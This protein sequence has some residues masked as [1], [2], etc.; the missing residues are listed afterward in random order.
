MRSTLAVLV[1]TAFFII[2]GQARAQTLKVEQLLEAWHVS[3]TSQTRV[4][5]ATFDDLKIHLNKDSLEQRVRQIKSFL[6]HHPDKRLQARLSMYEAWGKRISPEK[7]WSVIQQSQI[8][9]DEQL[10]SELFT[11]YSIRLRTEDNGLYYLLKAIEI[12]EKIGINQFPS[13]YYTYFTVSRWMYETMDY[14]H[15]VNYGRKGI[16][17]FRLHHNKHFERYILALDILGAAYKELGMSDS[18]LFY[19]QK[20]KEEL[21]YQ[22]ANRAKSKHTSQVISIWR[23][24]AKGGIAQALLLQKKYDSAYL[25]LQQNMQSS[26]GH[27]EWGDAA[28]VSNTMAQINMIKKNYSGALTQYKQARAWSIDSKGPVNRITAAKG[29][30]SAFAALNKYDS[31][32]HY[33]KEYLQWHDSLER[34]VNL[35]QLTNAQ[36]QVQYENMQIA[37]AAS[38]SEIGR[39]KLLRN[40][41][42]ISV[43]SLTV[44]ALMFYNRSLLKQKLKHEKLEREK[45]QAEAEVTLAQQELED[46]AKHISEKNNLIET[47]QK[48]ASER[49]QLD[50]DAALYNFAILTEDDWL[51]FKSM[52]TQAYPHF[53]PNLKKE[54]PDLNPAELRF[55]SLYKLNVSRK[56]MAATLGITLAAVDKQSYRLRKKL[57]TVRPGMELKDFV[58]NL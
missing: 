21:E 48:K 11:T 47:L 31:A 35:F 53:I 44:I 42:L 45:E 9:G 37:F 43:A 55:L 10:M 3:D 19:Y 46:F 58:V 16:A 56:E 5:E 23:G 4:A 2:V 57:E 50:I 33:Q 41:I 30:S 13:M 7:F 1:S 6:D 49:T 14:R 22:N 39:Q 38:Q 40:I 32:F 15:S 27:R 20:I 34:K 51:K 36:S 54:L 28:L 8:L 12:Q 17:S 52:F 25:L 29:I 26:I 24:I 18:T